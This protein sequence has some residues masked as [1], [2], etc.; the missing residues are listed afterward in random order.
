MPSSSA[1]RR[2]ACRRW[3]AKVRHVGDHAAAGE[4]FGGSQIGVDERSRRGAPRRRCCV[5]GR[6]RPVRP[7][8]GPRA[9]RRCFGRA[10]SRCRRAGRASR[11]PHR[12]LADEAGE[13]RAE[14]RVAVDAVEGSM[15]HR[16][17]PRAAA[18][19]GRASPSR[20]GSGTSRRSIPSPFSRSGRRSDP[21]WLE[22]TTL[23]ASRPQPGR[24]PPREGAVARANALVIASCEV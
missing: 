5:P 2:R 23:G 21:G 13:E 4:A 15:G 12:H 24:A 17:P 7:E 10:R 22:W 9:A 19:P 16:E 8:R 20:A 18:R 1:R 3:A 6:G 11:I 14:G